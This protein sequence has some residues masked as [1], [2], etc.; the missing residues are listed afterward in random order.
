MRVSSAIA[1]MKMNPHYDA[2]AG[3]LREIVRHEV[4]D[5][6]MLVT[7]YGIQQARSMQS[8]FGG[9]LEQ[10]TG[11]F[12]TPRTHQHNAPTEISDARSHVEES[13]DFQLLQEQLLF[14]RL[15][16]IEQLALFY[17]KYAGEVRDIMDLFFRYK[18][19]RKCG[20]T[21][22]AHL[23]RVG[24]VVGMMSMDQQG[25]HLYSTVGFMHDALEDLLDHARDERGQVY[26]VRGYQSFLDRYVAPEL[27]AHLKLVTNVY[28][29]LLAEVQDRMKNEGR[30]MSKENLLWAFEDMYTHE[31]VEIHPYI[32]K[33]HYALGDAV[34]EGDVYG[35]AKWKCYS[36][37]YIREMAIY[38]H[39][40]EDYRTFEIKAIDLSDNGHG[41]DALSMSSRMKNLIKHQIYAHYGTRLKSTWHGINNR[42]AELQEDALVHA[43]H[44][45]IGDLLQQQSYMDFAVSTMLKLIGMKSIFFTDR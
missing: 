31:P 45:I 2:A 40:R 21:S 14:G 37:L 3:I 15:P 39:S 23:H 17:G 20:I 35:Q 11:D 1:Q 38:T 28:D 42:V 5:L 29:L 6:Q 44:I 9:F 10:H 33:M 19:E 8:V 24:A 25:E 16:D 26:G 36:E 12:G 22:A 13:A 30:Y 41:R 7:L 4:P 34:L 32:E 27:H 18:L 43:E